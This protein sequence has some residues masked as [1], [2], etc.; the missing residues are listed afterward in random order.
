MTSRLAIRVM[1]RSSKNGIDGVRDGRILVRVT[2]PP[3][4]G[5]ANAAVVAVIA[6]AL[7]LPRHAVRVVAGDTS[8]NKTVEITGVD[9]AA[10]RARLVE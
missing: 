2:A 9:P 10:A 1:P 3:V 6:A 8:R 4:E 7:D 5:A